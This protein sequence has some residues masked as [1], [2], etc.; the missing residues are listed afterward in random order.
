[1]QI[2]HSS[3]PVRIATAAA[4]VIVFI[5]LFLWIG[6][7]YLA[8]VIASTATAKNLTTASRLDPGDA[9]YA[10]FLG[11]LYQYSVLN[12]QP[13]LAMNELN[14]S[15]RLNAYDPQAWLDLGTALDFE[16]KNKEAEA[17]MRRADFLAPRT[18][19]YQWAIGNFYLLHDNLSEAFRHFRM[20]LASVPYY[21]GQIFN[22]AWKASGDPDTILSGL[23][24][25]NADANLRYLGYLLTNGKLEDASAVWD[26]LA[27]GSEKFGADRAGLY[28]DLLVGAHQS[29]TAY[30]VWTVLREKGAIPATYESTPQNLIENG[31]F[32]NPVR[33][34]GF[35]WRITP[36]AGVYVGIDDSTFHSPSKSLLIQ[37]T[38]DQNV[39]YHNVYQLVPVLPNHHYHLVAYMKTQAITT[40]S[41]PR[42]EVRDAYNPALLDKY[43]DQLTGATPSWVPLTLD[44]ETGPKTDLISVN[45]ARIASGEFINKISGK[46]WVD[47][48]TLTPA[49][50]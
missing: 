47:D 34:V 48:V 39:D 5:A 29:S 3:K 36:L 17:S 23:I 37:F 42:M 10:L 40:D 28:M 13:E 14:R 30:K 2:T 45:V 49:G 4:G 46:F 43:T 21:D 9:S 16:G 33:D 44:F 12:A 22:I 11:R 41:G 38:G 18:P 35:D 24:P 20:V 27:R 15:V 25:D 7:D 31:D 6:R 1:M 32:E 26:R 50:D 19:N 8:T